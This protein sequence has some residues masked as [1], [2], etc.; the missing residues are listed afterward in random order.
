M[1]RS[2]SVQSALSTSGGLVVQ[3]RL[4]SIV[5]ADDA[6]AVLREEPELLVERELRGVVLCV[7]L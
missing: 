3:L 7:A 2:T 4:D 1:E 5:S 6:R